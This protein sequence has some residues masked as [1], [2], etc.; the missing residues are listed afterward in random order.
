LL[1]GAAAVLGVL[2]ALSAA[3]PPARAA[4]T[5]RLAAEA[6]TVRLAPTSAQ[7]DVGE[8]VDVEIWLDDVADYYTFD[9]RVQF[10]PDLLDV[11][12]GKVT[13][14]WDL[15]DQGNKWIIRNRVDEEEGGVWYAVSNLNPAEPFDGTGRVCR[16]TFRGLTEGIS[17]LDIAYAQG[18]TRYGESLSPDRVHGELRVGSEPEAPT[19]AR[20]TPTTATVGTPGLTLTIDGSGFVTDSVVQWDG[21]PRAT[22]FLSTTRLT[23]AVTAADLE[24]AGPVSITVV[25]PGEASSA[26]LSFTVVHPLPSITTL[27]PISTTAGGDNLTLHVMGTG[28]VEASTLHWGGVPH[29]TTVLSSTRLTAVIPADN[30]AQ[31]GAVPVWVVNPEPGGGPSNQLAFQITEVNPAPDASFIYLPLVASD[32]S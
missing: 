16:I 25:N 31:P 5:A 24:T 1:L 18:S 29:T 32:D 21:D 11:P 20:L 10:D 4:V 7:L 19:V 13:P 23:A 9:V 27:D 22:T 8:S 30:V 12:A 15:F 17:T 14:L 28:F 2:A 26:S 6:G 3:Q